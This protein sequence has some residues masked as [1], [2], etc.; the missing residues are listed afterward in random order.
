[1]FPAFPQEHE[2][3]GSPAKLV[4]YLE[5]RSFLAFNPPRVDRVDQS[6]IPF[7]G[8]FPDY[9]ERSIEVAPDRDYLRPVTLAWASSSVATAPCGITTTHLFPA[10]AA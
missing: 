7:T 3:V 4:H 8:Q 10:L 6:N 2:P 1:M 9:G 5:S